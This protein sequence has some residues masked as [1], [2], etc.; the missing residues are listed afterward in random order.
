MDLVFYLIALLLLFSSVMVVTQ[1]SVFTSALYLAVALSMVA[2]LFVLLNA[3][4]LAAV[5]I[6]LYVGGIL[7]LL[8]FAVMLSSV[9]QAKRETQVNEQWL[10]SLIISFGILLVLLV[11]LKRSLFLEAGVQKNHFYPTTEKIGH[12]LLGELALPFEVVSLVLLASLVGAILFSKK[13]KI[14]G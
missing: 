3:D 1:K 9:E 5:Q 2:A 10:P 6:L 8:A 14:D 13:E 7:V 4:F 12:L 11:S